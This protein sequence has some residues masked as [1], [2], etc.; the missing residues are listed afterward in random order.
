MR[1]STTVPGRAHRVH[2]P[3]SMRPRPYGMPTSDSGH[4][5]PGDLVLVLAV[6]LTGILLLVLSHQGALGW[7]ES[8]VV[9]DQ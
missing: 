4:V 6:D 8:M 7:V 1:P 2:A 3:A 9:V 5:L